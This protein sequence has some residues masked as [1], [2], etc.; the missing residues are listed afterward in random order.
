MNIGRTRHR[1]FP[2]HARTQT[3]LTLEAGCSAQAQLN[4]VELLGYAF[5][6]CRAAAEQKQSPR[7]RSQGPSQQEAL[8]SATL[9]LIQAVRASLTPSC[10]C[11]SACMCDP[12][13]SRCFVIRCLLVPGRATQRAGAAAGGAGP[14]AAA[15]GGRHL[16]AGLGRRRCAAHASHTLTCITQMLGFGDLQ[17]DPV[18]THM[19]ARSVHAGDLQQ[20]V[21]GSLDIPVCCACMQ[22]WAWW[23]RSGLWTKGVPLHLAVRRLQ[24]RTTRAPTALQGSR[25]AAPT[26][27]LCV[28]HS[29]GAGPPCF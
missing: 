6:A 20:A 1:E 3:L 5:Q 13:C 2:Q 24:G 17:R 4:L 15:A 14:D 9:L 10:D 12:D 25:C 8:L 26:V 27:V 19:Q 16:G 18:A 28:R 7:A 23:S 11:F 21:A 29:G 22:A